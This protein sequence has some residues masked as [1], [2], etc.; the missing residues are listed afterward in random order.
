MKLSSQLIPNEVGYIV[1]GLSLV[2][3]VSVSTLVRIPNAAMLVT[4]SDLECAGYIQKTSPQV[5]C[6]PRADTFQLI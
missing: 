4:Y 1:A 3:S 6:G 5:G 2:I